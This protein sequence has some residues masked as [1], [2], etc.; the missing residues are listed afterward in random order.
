MY[1]ILRIYNAYNY[2]CIGILSLSYNIQEGSPS[3]IEVFHLLI[4]FARIHLL[5]FRF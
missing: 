4:H 5:T 3:S 2:N 1:N